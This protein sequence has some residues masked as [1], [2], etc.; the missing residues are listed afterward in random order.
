MTFDEWWNDDEERGLGAN[1]FNGSYDPEA[2]EKA[3]R[4]AWQ[5]AARQERAACAK[6]CE[7]SWRG[8]STISRNALCDA[9]AAI[10]SR[11]SATGEKG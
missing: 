7:D 9:A 8:I 6:V 11:S 4:H 2:V 3:A 10:R 5:E 1:A